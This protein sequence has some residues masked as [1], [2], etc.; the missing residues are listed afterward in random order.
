MKTIK[1]DILEKEIKHLDI[2][3]TKAESLL[4]KF[5]HDNLMRL[6]LEQDKFRKENLIEEL[7]IS[8]AENKER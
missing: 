7:K 3:I 8:I 4:L 2:L 1:S 6:T 5:P